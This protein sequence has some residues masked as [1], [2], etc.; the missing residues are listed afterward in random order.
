VDVQNAIAEQN[1]QVAAGKL[2]D[3][4]APLDTVFDYQIN[5]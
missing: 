1:I 4:P 5:A 3:D 2:G